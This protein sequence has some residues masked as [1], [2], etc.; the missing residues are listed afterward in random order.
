MCVLLFFYVSC[1]KINEKIQPHF[2]HCTIFSLTIFTDL[3]NFYDVLVIVISIA[4]VIS[5]AFLNNSFERAY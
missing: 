3:D 4:L 1:I 5:I 2:V